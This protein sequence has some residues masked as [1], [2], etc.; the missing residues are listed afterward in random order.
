MQ[1][2]DFTVVIARFRRPHLREVFSGYGARDV[3]VLADGERVEFPGGYLKLFVEDAGVNRDSALLVH[4]DGQTF[5]DLNDCKIHDRAGRIAREDGPIDVFTSQFSG[6]IW[7]PPCY[8][9]E[10]KQYET[11]SR[12]KCFSKFEAVARTIE[13]LR[14]RII[15][16]ARGLP[17]SSIRSCSA[18]TSSP[19]ASSPARTASSA[20][21]RSA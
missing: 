21:S 14:P 6:A 19:S 1:K 17:A 18:S 4:G 10:K 16:R 7:H 9:Y 3:R 20:T 11:I 2:R 15:S 12:R 8:E 13:T 5:L